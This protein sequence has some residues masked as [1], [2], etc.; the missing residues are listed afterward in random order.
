[1]TESN[2]RAARPRRQHAAIGGR[3]LAAGLSASG[4]LALTAALATTTTTTA[5]ASTVAAAPAP[6][7][8]VVRVVLAD[9]REALTPVAVTPIPVP[10]APAARPVT[11]SKT[12]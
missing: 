2:P 1:M 12:S 5:K 10:A 11:A 9:G 3:V 7:T 8:I 6:Q 4:A